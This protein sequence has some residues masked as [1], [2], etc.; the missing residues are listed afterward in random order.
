MEEI[1]IAER[2]AKLEGSV[3]E[4][5]KTKRLKLFR[6]A[7]ANKRR[8]KKG[9]VGILRVDE[10]GNMAGERQKVEDMTVRL[11]DGTYHATDGREVLFWE[12]KFPVIIQPTWKINPIQLRKDKEVNEVYGQKYIMA[13]MLRDAIIMKNKGS[14]SIII[15]VLVIG[16]AALAIKYFMGK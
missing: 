2:L 5:V 8:I 3:Q 13:R 4:D 6:K 14:M 16:A 9:W 15:W 1:S 11:K 7:K 10:N 12:G